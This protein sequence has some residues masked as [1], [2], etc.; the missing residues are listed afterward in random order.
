MSKKIVSN[1]NFIQLK[2]KES[3]KEEA[4]LLVFKVARS[5]HQAKIYR[6]LLVINHEY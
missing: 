5:S 1:Y 3:Q 4:V 2:L 6:V